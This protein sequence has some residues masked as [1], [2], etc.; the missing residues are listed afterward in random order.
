MSRMLVIGLDCAT[1][2]VIS[3]LSAKGKLPTL[4]HLLAQGCS[5]PLQ[6]V[7]NMNSAPAW[8]S[9]ATGTNPGKHGIFYFA[10]RVPGTYRWQVVNGSHRKGIAFWDILSQA[11]CRVGV[12]NV[13]M[14]YP[15][16]SLNGFFIAGL[17]TPGIDSPGFTHPSDLAAEMQAQ[18]GEY[19]IEPGLPGLMKAGR[20]EEAVRALHKGI[21][22]RLAHTL[23]LARR[24][25][26]DLLAVVFTA[27]DTAQHFF[28]HAMDE[29]HPQH[30]A[31]EAA[32]FG[33]V[34]QNVYS[35]LDQAVE[36]LV[37][38]TSPDIVMILSDH[39]AGLNQRGADYLRPWLVELGMTTLVD[40]KSLFRDLARQT[41]G[42][43]YSLIDRHLPRETK[44]RLARRLPRLRSRVESLMQL[45]DIDWSHTQAYCTGATDDLYVNLAGRDPEGTVEPGPQYEKVGSQLCE[46]LIGTV[47]SASGAPAVQRVERREEVYWGPEVHK[48]PDLLIQW[49]TETVLQGL[50]T[51]G[52][53]PVPA[54]P[55]PPPI[56]T[57][58]HRPKGI[59]I[60]AGKDI[61]QQAN[62]QDPAIVDLAPMILYLCGLPIPSDMDG[63]VLTEAITPQHLAAQPVKLRGYALEQQRTHQDYNPEESK[64]IE[65]R[66]RGLGYLE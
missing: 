1:F 39:G 35:A 8:S 64:E 21:Q 30:T 44:L 54:E 14:T 57:G 31:Q 48:S 37:D 66:L 16:H 9:F 63:R 23:W 7:P 59:L 50:L 58:G 28:W 18:V 52:H 13:P 25:T 17:D 24:F 33:Q 43:L 5:A 41:A 62:L 22:Q 65:E 46:W 19:I 11:G 49:R 26:P 29:G 4:S 2:D 27:A 15:A 55:T 3:P 20:R 12:I 61:Q 38:A 10:Q 51:P 47:D 60:L 6:S 45:G 36:R 53:P 34:I 56:I 32:Q 42:R 40:Q